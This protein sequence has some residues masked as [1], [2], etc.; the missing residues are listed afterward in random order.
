LL[1]L[2]CGGRSSTFDPP[3]FDG[4]DGAGDRPAGE[5][6]D[7]GSDAADVSRIDG[8]P[9]DGR[10]A[11]GAETDGP[12][13]DHCDGVELR[14]G[15]W[16]YDMA[17][18]VV[19][20]HATLNGTELPDAATDGSQIRGVLIFHEIHT[21]MQ[22]VADLGTTGP[23]RYRLTI[24][25]GDYEVHLAYQD[26]DC[27]G[28]IVDGLP[29]NRGLLASGLSF[30]ED[31]SF[32]VD[33]PAVRVSGSV[34]LAGAQPAGGLPGYLVF[35]PLGT[36]APSATNDDLSY[37]A[38]V[39]IPVFEMPQYAVTLLPG[40]YSVVFLGNQFGCQ[41]TACNDLVV[42]TELTLTHD[43]IF[44]VVLEPATLGGQLTV[45]GQ[46]VGKA[47]LNHGSLLLVPVGDSAT[48]LPTDGQPVVTLPIP[49]TGSYSAPLLRGTYD[50]HYSGDQSCDPASRLPCGGGK[51]KEAVAVVGDTRLDLDIPSVTLE[52]RATLNGATFP[53]GGGV[54]TR[55]QLLFTPSQPTVVW[56]AVLAEL[57]LSGEATYQIRLLPG[58]HTV[59][60]ETPESDPA[61]ALRPSPFPCPS[62]PVLRNVSVTADAKL[63]VDIRTISVRGRVHQRGATLPAALVQNS[64]FFSLSGGSTLGADGQFF[65]PF[66]PEGEATYQMTL[67]PGRYRVAW[68]G[69]RSCT[70]STPVLPCNE[71]P[72]S[73]MDLLTDAVLDVDLS[74]VVVSG[75]L[76]LN[77]AALPDQP[78]SRGAIGFRLV[79]ESS[80]S[81][82][83]PFGAPLTATGPASY[84]A[85]LL[86]GRYLISFEASSVLPCDK[87]ENPIACVG[88][89]ILDGCPTAT[90]P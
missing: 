41:S 85:A 21:G 61:C 53:D 65:V 33:I 77:G 86:P 49:G 78:A 67:L 36:G 55:G 25:R 27:G 9:S 14:S 64:V 56:S 10:L 82:G 80:T 68:S 39:R 73:E 38:G 63:D 51:L 76:T 72:V 42:T 11:D 79:D 3:A 70:D 34:S 50:V 6:A 29:C 24:A 54:T 52:G 32:D 90:P 31:A 46:P 43:R 8:P 30:T 28:A 66:P 44:D 13:S 74:P 35:M 16:N 12:S 47:E 62:G 84:Q 87:P 71:G 17:T 59:G 83:Q 37:V 7:P 5:L 60:Y 26:S 40:A 69:S 4:S 19:E 20:G 89:F 58:A 18:V 75:V 45:N 22:F 2:G 57:P 15:V 81:F 1:S 88:D 48:G 23:A